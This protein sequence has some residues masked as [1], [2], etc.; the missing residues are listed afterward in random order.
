MPRDNIDEN[1]FLNYKKR[2]NIFIA[3]IIKLTTFII[4]GLYV[5]IN[6]FDLNDIF[7]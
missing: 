5:I 7:V 4:S 2:R 3:I 6:I 1:L